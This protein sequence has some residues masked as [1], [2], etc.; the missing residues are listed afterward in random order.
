ML[1]WKGEC[2]RLNEFGVWIGMSE[3]EIMGYKIGMGEGEREGDKAGGRKLNWS[4]DWSCTDKK[5]KKIFL[6]KK[7]I[8]MGAAAES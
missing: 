4:Y 2:E 6:I 7:E 5:E 3:G 1:E 8:Q